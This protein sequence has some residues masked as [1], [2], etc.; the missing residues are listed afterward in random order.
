MTRL[1]LLSSLL[2]FGEEKENNGKRRKDERQAEVRRSGGSSKLRLLNVPEKTTKTIVD[3][4]LD[5]PP[6][7]L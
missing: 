3:L 5:R 6:K 4:Y 2:G 1:A 7:R